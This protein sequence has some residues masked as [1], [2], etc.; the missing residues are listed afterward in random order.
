MR[1]LRRRLCVG[2]TLTA[3]AAGCATPA[4]AGLRAQGAQSA[5]GC[6]RV[7]TRIALAE[8]AG[9]PDVYTALPR[10]RSASFVA[11]FVATPK[12]TGAQDP[13]P[14]I[15]VFTLRLDGLEIVR[16]NGP[17][18][19]VQFGAGATTASWTVTFLG[20]GASHVGLVVRRAKPAKTT[21]RLTIGGPAGSGISGYAATL[22]AP[23]RL[24]APGV[25]ELDKQRALLRDNR[26]RVF[27]GTIDV[28]RCAVAD[29]GRLRLYYRLPNGLQGRYAQVPV[30]RKQV[31]ATKTAPRTHVAR[32]R[33]S[34]SVRFYAVKP[35]AGQALRFW[36]RSSNGASSA[37]RSVRVAGA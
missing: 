16:G 28:P 26:R 21:V 34:V 25:I 2:L 37:T 7:D 15:C 6:G 32:C 30:L 1:S 20:S 13:T 24:H 3:L 23:R 35:F 31:T 9:G 17:P 36:V 12:A 22:K 27:T 11:R 18:P 29:A 14:G 33:F 19:G 10:S 4:T 8:S 5:Y